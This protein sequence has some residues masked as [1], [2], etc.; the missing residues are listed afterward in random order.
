MEKNI[1]KSNV[2][3]ILNIQTI[4]LDCEKNKESV[5]PKKTLFVSKLETIDFDG[6]LK[7]YNTHTSENDSG[8]VIKDTVVMK[9]ITVSEEYTKP[10]LRYNEAGLIKFLEKKGI[11]R[12]STYSSII[13]NIDRKY[14][15]QKC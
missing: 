7:L 1:S 12:P 14:V 3:A 4:K 10:P 5:L 8:H 6:F 11:G 2:D 15:E 9:S 13:S